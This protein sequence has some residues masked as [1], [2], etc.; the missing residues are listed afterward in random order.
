MNLSNNKAIPIGGYFELELPDTGAIPYQEAIRFQSARVAFL[1]LLQAGTPERVWMPRFICDAMVASLTATGIECV[2][3]DIDEKLSIGQDIEIGANE[4]LLYVN[5]YGICKRNVDEILRRFPPEQ[6]VL[7]FSQAFFEPPIDALSTIYSPRKFFGVPDGGLMICRT[8]AT[9][10]ARQDKGSFERTS[11]L[12]QRL[13]DSPEAGYDDYKRAEESL[14]GCEP[15]QM[16][17]LTERILATVDYA[18][19]IEKR[20]NNFKHLHDKLG[21]RNLFHFDAEE[22]SA[23]LCYPFMT[24]DNDLRSRLTNARIFVPTYWPDAIQRVGTVWA[25]K[26]IR[27]LLP[28]PVDQRYGAEDMERMVSVILGG[29]I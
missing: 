11:H 5:Y 12:L 15:L 9:L 16:S 24:N 19:C 7:D 4:W 27:N 28:L 3:Y 1:A 2:W 21:D 29:K 22:V 23:P 14:G 18:V 20:R 26:Y 6:V 10:P 8:L 17:T 25:G 13:G